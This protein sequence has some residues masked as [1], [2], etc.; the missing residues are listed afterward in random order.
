MDL[1]PSLIW[2]DEHVI[3]LN[4]P[5]GLLTLPDGFDLNAPHIK[6]LL[7]PVYGSLWIVH[8]LDRET[9]GVMVCARTA[10]S[11]RNLNDQFTQRL[12]RKV[13]HVLVSGSPTWD[14][15]TVQLP[16]LVN[17]D[18]HHRT[19][20]DRR[21]GKHSL[22]RLKVLQR[23]RDYTLVEATPHTGRTHQ[24]RTHL[25]AIGFPIVVDGLYGDG[26]SIYLSQIKPDYRGETS[27][28][29]PLLSRMGL[30]AW[31]LSF[32]HPGA[33]SMLSFQAEYPKDMSLTIKQLNKYS[34][35]T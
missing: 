30:H 20:V 6:S 28:E 19:I 24:I 2:S 14:E 11:H 25:A 27:N 8:R 9:S 3:V 7:D 33:G 34:L 26:L 31:S 23:F 32:G 12:V 21:R 35:L 29:H 18:R 4:K 5:A 17:G 10:E 13:Y 1:K 22:T 16:L 15:T